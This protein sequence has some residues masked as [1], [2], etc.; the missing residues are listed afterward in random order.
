MK[1]P[2]CQKEIPDSSLICIFCNAV[3]SSDGKIIAGSKSAT[4]RSGKIKYRLI[5][6]GLVLAVIFILAATIT[7]Y[8]NNKKKTIA[9]YRSTCLSNLKNISTDLNMYLQD[10]KNS[11]LLPPADSNW[12]AFIKDSKNLTCPATGLAYGAITYGYNG[13]VGGKN[14]ISSFNGDLESIPLISECDNS[15]HLI[16]KDT[17]VAKSRHFDEKGAAGYCVLTM[18][19]S[20]LFISNTV[21]YNW[22]KLPLI[23]PATIGTETTT[24]GDAAA[25]TATTPS[26]ADTTTVQP[27]SPAATTPP[28][29]STK[30]ATSTPGKR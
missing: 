6:T 23:A 29:A 4:L 8:N 17:D 27:V 25:T 1:C 28:S 16:M 18:S 2:S 3:F 26:V 9:T 30:P 14:I 21:S 12:T 24:S 13:N 15:T 20:I 22:D 10:S 5:I 11:V 19:G 7:I